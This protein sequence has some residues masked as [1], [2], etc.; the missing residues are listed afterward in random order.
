MNK[1]VKA[2]LPVVTITGSCLI[3]LFLWE[4]YLRAMTIKAK[5]VV[6]PTSA[7]STATK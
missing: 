1:F 5:V 2:A 7:A 4:K 3:A 6:T